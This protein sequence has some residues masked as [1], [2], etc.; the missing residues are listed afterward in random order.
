MRAVWYDRTGPAGEVLVT[1]ELPDP[2]PAAGEVR[3]RVTAAG[4]NPR[5]VKRR[6]AVGDRT[7]ADPRVI[8]GDD[9][10]GIVDRVGPGVSAARIGQRVWVHS[11]TCDRAFGTAA[12]YV[13]VP[14]GHAIELPGAASFEAGACL[15]VPA[16]TA[17]RC[18]FAD[19]PV[20]GATVLVIGGAGM[21]AHVGSPS[22]PC[23]L[24]E[25]AAHQHVENGHA[26]GKVLILP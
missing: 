3:V 25:A 23:S 26:P 8:P 4:V 10:A 24:G 15:G 5:D 1:G 19:G 6:A 12:E 16:L 14:A 21:V 9:G 7:M 11:A 17:H 13:V 18:V 22:A 20:S 2:L